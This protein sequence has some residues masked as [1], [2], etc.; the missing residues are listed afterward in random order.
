MISYR[1][2]WEDLV[3]ILLKSCSRGPCIKILK[4]LCG[5]LWGFHGKFLYEDLLTVLY[6][7]GPCLTI[8]WNSLRCLG[9][10]SWWVDIAS[11]LVPKQVPAAA[12]AKMSNLICYSS[13]AT[14]ACTW[15]IGFLPPA[16]FGA[17]CRCNFCCVWN[18]VCYTFYITF[19]GRDNDDQP[20]DFRVR[21]V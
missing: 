13:I 1:S 17:S 21:H 15:H 11:L 20:V 3:E 14:V 19:F 10:R 4:M 6:I 2:L 9:M 8:F 16:L 7:E 5:V 12:V 18:W